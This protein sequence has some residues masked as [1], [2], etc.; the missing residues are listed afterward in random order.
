MR[1]RRLLGGLAFI[2][3]ISISAILG[4]PAARAQDMTKGVA[5]EPA[6]SEETAQASVFDV[7]AEVHAQMGPVLYGEPGASDRL[8]IQYENNEPSVTCGGVVLTPIGYESGRILLQSE[9]GADRCGKIYVNFQGE[10]V[11]QVSDLDGTNSS[12][13]I[14]NSAERTTKIMI[15]QCFLNSAVACTAAECENNTACVWGPGGDER[16]WCQDRGG[17]KSKKRAHRTYLFN[18]INRVHR[19]NR[20]VLK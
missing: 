3:A 2:A 14:V 16:A 9:Y 12:R 7:F 13:Y 4:A 17:R 6:V 8:L 10:L 5:E 20:V 19:F 11:V 18:R 15:C 1:L